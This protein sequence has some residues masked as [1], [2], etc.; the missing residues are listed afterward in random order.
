[1]I[2]ACFWVLPAHGQDVDLGLGNELELNF[3]VEPADT[4]RSSGEIATIVAG[5]AV[6]M[7]IGS[8]LAAL[9]FFVLLRRV[10]RPHRIVSLGQVWLLAIPGWNLLWS[11]VLA[12]AVTRSYRNALMARAL[13]TGVARG[14]A[15]HGLRV[16]EGTGSN[17]TNA[18]YPIQAEHGIDAAMRNQPKP[19]AT[20][21]LEVPAGVL[22]NLWALSFGASFAGVAIPYLTGYLWP[23]GLIWLG[24]MVLLT[25]YYRGHSALRSELTPATTT[26]ARAA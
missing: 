7:A 20:T 21:L 18:D 6:A 8:S 19:T 13:E 9:P 16:A 10:P 5:A 1:M 14:R 2:A 23:T 4:T 12:N 17:G 25:W 15:G 22:G 26:H 3:D 24:S 11:F